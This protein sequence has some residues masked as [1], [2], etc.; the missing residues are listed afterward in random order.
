MDNKDLKQCKKCKEQINKKA[1]KCPH[2]G[3]KQGMPVWLIVII[4]IVVIGVFASLG[5]KS[6]NS[7]NADN[8]SIQ[9]QTQS[10]EPI[11]YISLSVDD[12]ENALEN[13][14]AAAKD[15]YNNKY[16]QISGR[17]GTIDSDLKYI[18][19][20]SPTDDWD[21]LGIHCTLKTDAQREAVKTLSKDQ[22]ITVKGKIT[23]VGEVLGYYLDVTEIY[24]N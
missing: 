11:E 20:L 10:Q 19:L 5:N 6:N 15:T 17:L 8:G 24:G 22:S 12:L 23:D 13:N 9:P 14:A 4:V 1:K 7:S 16:I 2:C 21:I 18:S 3:A